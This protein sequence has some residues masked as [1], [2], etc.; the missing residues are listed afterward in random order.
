MYLLRLIF[1]EGHEADLARILFAFKFRMSESVLAF[2]EVL[3]DINIFT[4]FLFF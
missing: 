1:K 4:F 3:I 2:D